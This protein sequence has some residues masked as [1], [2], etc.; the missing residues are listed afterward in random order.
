VEVE[1]EVEAEDEVWVAGL[2]HNRAWASASVQ[3][4][5]AKH[6]GTR[7][8]RTSPPRNSKYLRTLGMSHCRTCRLGRSE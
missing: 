3:V 1:V 8:A 2:R 7:P 6:L 5:A 4:S